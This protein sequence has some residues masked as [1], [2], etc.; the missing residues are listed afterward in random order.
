MVRGTTSDNGTVKR[1]LVNGKE[2]RALGANFAEWEILLE[3]VPGGEV[4]IEAHGEDAAGNIEQR[5]HA[6]VIHREDS[7]NGLGY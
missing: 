7:R 3:G 6:V 4:K 2:A 1:V 5:P